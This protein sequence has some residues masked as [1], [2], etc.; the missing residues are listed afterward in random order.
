MSQ[1]DPDLI[2]ALDEGTTSARS[3]VFDRSGATVAVAQREFEQRY[4]SPGDVRHDAEAI[5]QAQLATAREVIERAGGVDRIAAIGVTN[6]RETAVVWDRATGQ[7]VADAI[8][9]QSRVTAPFC[10]DLRRAG[11]ESLV[12][13]RTGLPIDAYFTGPKIRQIL[14]EMPA[15]RPRA[16][17]GE[18]AAGTIDSF[19][20]A[21]L[22]AGRTHVTDVSN[23]SRTL[24][25]DIRRGAWDAELLDLMDVPAAVLPAVRSSSETFGETDP[26]LFGRPIPIAGAAGDQQAA[27]FG[28]ACFQP[29]DAKV[30]LGTGAFLLANTGR[31]VVESRHGLLATVAWRLGPDAP[32]TYAIEGSVFVTGA[33]VQW[34][35]DGLG[36]FGDSSEV[37]VLAGRA[38]DTGGVVVVPAF[39]GLGAPYWDPTARGAI[40]G[41]TRGTGAAEIARATLEAVAFQ[42]RD[43]VE[44][45]D[46]DMARPLAQLRIDGGGAGDLVCG[47][48]A[49]QLGRPVERPVN[50]ETTAFGAAALAGL[51]VGFWARPGEIAALRRVERRF[52][53]GLAAPQRAAS[54][55]VWRRAVERARGWTVDD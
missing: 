49:D 28:Q 41:I 38:A 8:V 14:L 51:A 24:V 22:T 35:R 47:F 42:V 39:V 44:A 43:V 7:P 13:A 46:A 55:R 50:R 11:H 19:L 12:R 36:F 9:W 29:G 15:L 18:L 10:D 27:T 45:M 26:D 1:P 33:A 37:E 54:Y 6:Q 5:W 48:V 52:E 30:T 3:I 21:R 25:L 23:A 17:A 40:L 20:I 4:P 16:E 53:P 31:E 32:I 34:L 2:L